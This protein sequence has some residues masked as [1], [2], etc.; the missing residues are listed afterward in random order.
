MEECTRSIVNKLLHGCMAALRCDGSDPEVCLLTHRLSWTQLIRVVVCIRYPQMFGSAPSSDNEQSTQA[1]CG[2]NTGI[3]LAREGSVWSRGQS[4]SARH[5][6]S[7]H[8]PLSVG[9][10]IHLQLWFLHAPAVDSCFICAVF[11]SSTLL[12]AAVWPRCW[13]PLLNP[14]NRCLVHRS[15]WFKSCRFFNRSRNTC[16]SSCRCPAALFRG[17]FRQTRRI[18]CIQAVTEMLANMDALERMFGLS[19]VVTPAKR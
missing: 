8:S 7:A 2:S 10:T 6:A 14:I 12:L 1:V 17:C 3:I 18:G 5:A 11:C 13:G 19:T 9:T 16:I 4:R 15:K